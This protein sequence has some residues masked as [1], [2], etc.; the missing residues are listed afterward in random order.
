MS[1]KGVRLQRRTS[2]RPIP[3]KIKAFSARSSGQSYAFKSG[4][5]ATIGDENR[6][7]RGHVLN[8]RHEAASADDTRAMEIFD[9]QRRG[10]LVVPR[11]DVERL[12][13]ADVGGAVRRVRGAETVIERSLQRGR[14]ISRKVAHGAEATVLHADRFVI[15]K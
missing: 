7:A 6:R 12:V 8:L 15:G 13:L 10:D 4:I 14:V 1:A 3:I 9:R 2:G 5:A 11:R